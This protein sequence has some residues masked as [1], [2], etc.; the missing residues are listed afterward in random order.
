[1]WVCMLAH[2]TYNSICI[3]NKL[4]SLDTLWS[5]SNAV[6][7]ALYVTEHMPYIYLCA[8][9]GYFT[10]FHIIAFDSYCLLGCQTITL[11]VYKCF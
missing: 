1:M 10:F 11:N 8:W 7:Q 4:S 3:I 5:N 6:S 9:T 2:V